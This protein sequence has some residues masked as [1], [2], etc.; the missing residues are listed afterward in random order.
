[1]Q[2]DKAAL[3]IKRCMKRLNA[4]GLSLKL[5]YSSPPPPPYPALLQ[6]ALVV[7]TSPLSQNLSTAFGFDVQGSRL[8]DSPQNLHG[9]PENEANKIGSKQ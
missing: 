8:A 9:G 3:E 2:I 6:L 7:H 5:E 1:M 4:E